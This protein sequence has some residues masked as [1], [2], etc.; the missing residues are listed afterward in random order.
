[1]L[2]SQY[3]KGWEAAE[4]KE[5]E[6]DFSRK[7]LLEI[8]KHKYDMTHLETTIIIGNLLMLEYYGFL[9]PDEYNGIV[10]TSSSCNNL[11]VTNKTAFCGKEPLW[12][13]KPTM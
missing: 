2:F 9:V 6:A 12:R 10:I 7:Q 3:R 11:T 8:A 13:I 5:A 1:V 4:S